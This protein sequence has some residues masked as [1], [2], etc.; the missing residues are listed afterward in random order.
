MDTFRQMLSV[1]VVLASLGGLLWWLR[2]KGLARFDFRAS[3]GRVRSL[4]LVER[5]ALT[6]QHTL[7]LVEVQGRT[8]LVA[9]SQSG[10]SILEPVVVPGK[11]TVAV[12]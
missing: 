12:R 11:E 2:R 8:I 6:P 1:M 3:N 5:L 9:T 10:C 7:H 4:R